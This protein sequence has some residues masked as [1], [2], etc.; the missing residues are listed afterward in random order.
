MKTIL[1][2]LIIS[3]SSSALLAQ[4][5]YID[6]LISSY[7]G[8]FLNL[9]ES[10]VLPGAVIASPSRQDPNYFYHWV[11][12]AGLTMMEMVQLYQLPL[13]PERK[14]YIEQRIKSW[15]EF[16]IRNQ[17]TAAS[18]STLGEPIFTVTGDIYPYEWGRPQSDGPAIRALAMIEY[19]LSLIEQNRMNEVEILYRAE[20]P[21]LTP[22][23]RDLEYV[24]HQWQEPAYDLWEE[25]KGNHFFTRMAQRAALIKGSQLA[26]K[27]NDPKAAE[28]YLK[29]SHDIEVALLSHRSDARGYI[30]PTLNQT[31][32]WRH[33]TSE[34]DVSVI[35]ATL[36][37]SLNDGFLD[38]TDPW[39]FATA[40]KLEETFAQLYSI[41]K[42]K[43][44]SPA[45][46]RYPEDVYTGSGFGEGNPWFLATNA[47][48]EFY[49]RL[50][51]QSSPGEVSELLKK[52]AVSFL[53]RTIYHSN[54][55]GRLPEQ[56][57]R[58][59][60]YAQGARDLTWSYT[61]Y[62]RAFRFCTEDMN[63]I[64][65]SDSVWPF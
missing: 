31:D 30:V 20:L 9:S 32:G 38:V 53:D 45:I 18:K 58:N 39:V 64:S 14:A 27:L 24:A 26:I 55:G 23:K 19:A 60:G 21:S 59:S 4:D 6:A 62:I 49:C 56:F 5:K 61:S 7:R 10:G 16:E 41:N 43:N 3:F 25:V 51:R 40:K 37:F 22:I 28:Y 34:L 29:Q 50:A 54:P 8:I 63:Q 35:L 2:S 12:D 47:F 33:K 46:G 65:S 44:L 48:A 11:R 15:I 1:L 57:N 17:N 36:Y 42:N 52:K 13:K